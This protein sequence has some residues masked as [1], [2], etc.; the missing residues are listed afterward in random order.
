MHKGG[1]YAAVIY[2]NLTAAY[3]TELE[4]VLAG[5]LGGNIKT[6]QYVYD[7]RKL[8]LHLPALT[9]FRNP[10]DKICYLKNFHV[11][12]KNINAGQNDSVVKFPCENV[13]SDYQ[14]YWDA[15]LEALND[16]YSPAN[17]AL[18]AGEVVYNM[19][20]DWYNTFP[21][22]DEQGQAM[23]IILRLHDWGGTIAYWDGK[24][25]TFGD[26]D[27]VNYFPFVSLDIAAHEISH[28][29]TEQHSHL[30]Y[31]GE[32]GGLNESFSDM[33][34]KAA[35]YYAHG[36]LE[37][38][39]L[40]SSVVRGNHAFRYMDNPRRDCVDA[41]QKVYCSIDNLKDYSPNLDPHLT[42]GIYNKFFYLLATSPGWDVQKAFNVMVQANRAYWTSTT[43][44]S[45][46]ACGVVAATQDYGYGI[47]AVNSAF[48]AVGIDAQQCHR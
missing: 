40:G 18:A 29:F 9:L 45:E 12:V 6:G 30:S 24:V 4:P 16:A 23:P 42:S 8:P 38:W 39:E 25:V 28:G 41:Y 3:A 13:D 33:A 17:D 32:A 43:S 19:Y 21:L 48:A 11:I 15:N 44:F 27:A 10:D 5:G 34:S 26:G 36:K 35:E 2:L 37:N 20:R 46:A 14:L 47:T 22:V 31:D 7:N 1:L